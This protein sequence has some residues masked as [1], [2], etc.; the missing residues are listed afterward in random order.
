MKSLDLTIDPIPEI[1]FGI[2]Y[3]LE[4]EG[5]IFRLKVDTSENRIDFAPAS[6]RWLNEYGG[7]SICVSSDFQEYI[8]STFERYK[9]KVQFN[10]ASSC[11]WLK[12]MKKVKRKSDE[13]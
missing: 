3:N 8:R 13:T 12:K 7:Y 2:N 1:V 6:W 9:Y 10:S 11:F 4:K 5:A